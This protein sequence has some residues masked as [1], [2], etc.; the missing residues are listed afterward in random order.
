MHRECVRR[1]KALVREP[2]PKGAN[3][4]IENNKER[5]KER[6]ENDSA[7]TARTI[8]A[9][10][11][12]LN[13]MMCGLK[14]RYAAM[15][16]ARAALRHHSARRLCA[17]GTNAYTHTLSS[18]HKFRTAAAVWRLEDSVYA[19]FSRWSRR[20]RETSALGRQVCRDSLCSGDPTDALRAHRRHLHHHRRK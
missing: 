4:T 15:P 14:H 10:M 11:K 13:S 5:K 3:S 1:K 19:P 17:S 12:S 7:R 2:E 8:H 16:I 9:H 18:L 6:K 20:L